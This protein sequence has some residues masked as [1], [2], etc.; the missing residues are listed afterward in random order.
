MGETERLGMS[1]VRCDR[2][3]LATLGTKR[4][5]LVRD[6]RDVLRTADLCTRC[7]LELVEAVAEAVAPA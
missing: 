4:L 3:G 6:G 7:E 5:T 2:C 1:A